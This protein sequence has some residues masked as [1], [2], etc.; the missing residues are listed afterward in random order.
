MKSIKTK[1]SLAI[2]GVTVLI[3]ALMW[4]F[5]VVLLEEFYLAGKQS[6]MRDDTE[7][8]VSL[9]TD[10]TKMPES[11]LKQLCAEK[12]YCLEFYLPDR[13]TSIMVEP[14]GSVNLL[15]DENFRRQDIW[16]ELQN[17]PSGVF[18]ESTQQTSFEHEYNLLAGVV[19]TPNENYVLFVASE[20]APV[21]EAVTAIRT[22]LIFLSIVLLLVAGVLAWVLSRS[23]TRPI[24]KL[25]DAANQ[26]A[27]G[28]LTV[29]VENTT[30]DEIG[31]L[32]QNFNRMVQEI[33]RSNTLQRELVANVS[34][35]FRTPL[36]MIKGYAE[37]IKDLTG[38]NK[39]KREEQLDV[40]IAESNRL[41]L[42]T[43]DIL[44][45]SK[46]QSGRQPMNFSEFD[47][48][49]K[50][51]DVMRRYRLLAENEGFTFL[52]EAPE[53]LFVYA[54]EI[55]M[56]QVLF[57]IINNATNHTGA[58]KK[59]IV[60]LLQKEH[61]ARV[62]ISDTGE[63]IRPED[64]P[65]IW[66]RYYKPYKKKD[67]KGMGT[68]LG[69]SI[70]KAILVAHQAKY[71]VDSAPGMGTTFWFELKRTDK[72]PKEY[73]LQTAVQKQGGTTMAVFT[74]TK[75]NFEA[76]VIQSEKPVLL[77]FWAS[78]CAPCR[79]MSPIVDAVAEEMPEIKVGKV[80]VD[81]EPE[82]ASAFRVMSIPTL[83]LIKN[84]K[85]VDQM[86][87]VR[88]KSEVVDFLMK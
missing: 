7:L 44:D 55:K 6:E 48:G 11:A 71:G 2:A 51:S 80:N 72:P 27:A 63:G 57:N 34:H 77:D 76:E 87:G 42:L 46:L 1:I 69:L 29:R 18:L 68:G 33:D 81:D 38:D 43:N 66:E 13:E 83:A 39:Q 24:L 17:H 20:L 4:F 37:T 22:Q 8:I 26:V 14:T 15:R 19:T 45:L 12:N 54:D 75:D 82:L 65:L 21:R 5:Q 86:I 53:H 36:T 25:S 28:D 31:T 85:V 59:V 49:M 74:I 62:E 47:L 60:R 40:I 35:D 64:L 41:N 78:W 73:P 88:P 52:L 9:V 3:L 30:A 16:I 79:M 70:V 10:L 23:L 67:R 61:T 84:G 50:L 56:E 58:D 32:T